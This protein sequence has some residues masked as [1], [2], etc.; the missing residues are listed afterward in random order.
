M[1]LYILIGFKMREGIQKKS[2]S[3][4]IFLI[5]LL[6]KRTMFYNTLKM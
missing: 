4:I 6:K 2:I 5:L 3:I 1:I